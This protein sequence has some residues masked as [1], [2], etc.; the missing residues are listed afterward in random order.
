MGSF[1]AAWCTLM[2]AQTHTCQSLWRILHTCDRYLCAALIPPASLAISCFIS[3]L[4]ELCLLFPSAA[5][6]GCGSPD[7]QAPFFS[8]EQH[9]S[10]SL[11]PQSCI[12]SPLTLNYTHLPTP[13][14]KRAQNVL[15]PTS[16]TVATLEYPRKCYFRRRDTIAIR[17][18]KRHLLVLGNL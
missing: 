4:N 1:R 7:P 10:P 9:L 2:H 6:Q 13:H 5:L 12:R 15:K 8:S 16:N 18:S 3:L 11:C 17:R 14:P